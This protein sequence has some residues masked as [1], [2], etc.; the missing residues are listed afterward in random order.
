MDILQREQLEEL[1]RA[2]GPCVSIYMPTHVRGADTLQDPIRLKNLLKRSE[3]ELERYGVRS[4]DARTMLQPAQALIENHDFWRRQT[5]GLAIFVARNLFRHFRLPIELDETVL[6]GDRLYL[7]A[8]LKLMTGDGRY[9]VL[10]LSRDEVRLL[11][12]TRYGC[13][14]VALPDSVPKNFEEARQYVVDQERTTSL[15]RGGS[16]AG[17][18]F[19][20]GP[21]SEDDKL[22]I[23]EYFQAV[24]KGLRDVFREDRV[25]LVFAGVDYLLPLYREATSYPNLLEQGIHGNPEG[26]SD[27]ELHDRAWTIV[28]PYFRKQQEKA[29]AQF[30]SLQPAGRASHTIK[31]VVAAAHQGRVDTLFVAAGLQH[32][33][34]FDPST[35]QSETHKQPEPGDDDL[36]DLAALQTLLKGGK[37]FAVEPG[38]IPDGAPLAAVYRY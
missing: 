11:E 7:K 10:A 16:G 12:C 22:R 31:E 35:F 30:K 27:S 25:P 32:W 13:H 18:F 37:V 2:A 26:W 17:V 24:D 21:E 6:V 20:S 4:T 38:E 5:G 33:G 23:K 9:Y 1:A 14:R 8:L 15:A 28:E 34:R 19:G 29:A 3:Q 36:L